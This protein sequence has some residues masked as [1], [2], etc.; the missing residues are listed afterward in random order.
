M[1]EKRLQD[2]RGRNLVYDGFVLL[3]LAAGLIEQLLCLARGQ[4]FVPEMNGKPA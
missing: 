3:P 4:A 2:Q 1:V